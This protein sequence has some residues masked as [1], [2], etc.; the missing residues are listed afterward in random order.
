MQSDDLLAAVFPD[1]TACQ[2]NAVA[3]PI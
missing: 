2:D 1:Q 3:G